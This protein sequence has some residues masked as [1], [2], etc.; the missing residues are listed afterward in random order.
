MPERPE[1]VTDEQIASVE[2]Q[3]ADIREHPAQAEMV[4]RHYRY[5]MTKM[6]EQGIA[7]PDANAILAQSYQE[8]LEA[9]KEYDQEGS[10]S[11]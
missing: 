7:Q 1:D 8:V 10:A 5:H 2:R 3:I 11:E 4:A 6:M 9:D